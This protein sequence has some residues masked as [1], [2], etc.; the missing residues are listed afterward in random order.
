MKKMCLDVYTG[1]FLIMME[2]QVRTK[3]IN[4]RLPTM[5]LAIRILALSAALAGLAAASNSS[6]TTRMLP[7]SQAAPA[8]MPVPLC[9]PGLPG[10]PDTPSDPRI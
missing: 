5:K 2:G 1:S 6:A 8:K 10:C 4:E 3:Q 9:A 7:S